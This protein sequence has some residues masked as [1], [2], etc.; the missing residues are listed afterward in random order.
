MGCDQRGRL[1]NRALARRYACFGVD[2]ACCG[3]R[4]ARGANTSMIS[5]SIYRLRSLDRVNLCRW[6]VDNVGNDILLNGVSTGNLNEQ[7]LHRLD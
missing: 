2:R 5:L 3:Y 4:W 1:P 7:W 6:S